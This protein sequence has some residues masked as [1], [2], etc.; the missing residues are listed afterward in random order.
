M[1]EL[2]KEQNRYKQAET[3]IQQGNYEDAI[4]FLNK[5]IANKSS[6]LY[7]DALWKEANCL[8]SLKKTKEAKE[9]FEKLA[10]SQ[11]KYSQQAKAEL[12]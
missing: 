7:F 9:I 6:E 2:A 11:N 5:I 3:L 4:P 10:N 8:K 12:K 1:N